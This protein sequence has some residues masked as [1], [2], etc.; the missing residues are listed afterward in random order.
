VFLRSTSVILTLLSVLEALL[1]DVSKTTVVSLLNLS[2]FS[3]SLLLEP[4]CFFFMTHLEGMTDGKVC[5]AGAKKEFPCPTS[6]RV[7]LED[8]WKLLTNISPLL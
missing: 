7:T 3:L 1:I 8:L 2:L 4:F 6:Q 5:R